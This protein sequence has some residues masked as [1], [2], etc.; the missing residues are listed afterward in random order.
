[1]DLAIEGRT[2]IVAGASRG[3]GLGIARELAR[4]G[5]RVA[6]VGRRHRRL[7]PEV[8]A[9]NAAGGV[10]IAIEADMTDESEVSRAV[11]ETR[12][13]F[14]NPDIA[15]SM[16]FYVTTR[17][18]QDVDRGFGGTTNEE[19]RKIMDDIVMNVVYLTR[20]V[21]PGMKDRRWGRLINIGTVAMK[22]PHR[23]DPIISSNIRVAAC[24]L[25]KTLA[26]E[27]GQYG[28]TA[29]VIAP[30]PVDTPYF[31]DYVATL[32]EAVNTKDKWRELVPMRRLGTEDDA[33]ALAAFLASEK[34]SW[35]TGQTIVLD[36]GY[37]RNLY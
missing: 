30:G 3:M 24:G 37:A 22:E 32:P 27:Y 19:F 5:V 9:I 35:I 28:I 36:G 25:M 8:E 21:L 2:A 11:A 15:V 31:G 12:A 13:V 14:G 26:N 7:D 33:G 29:N 16:G 34:A 4:E 10:A 6:M 20:E 17:H 1:V 18:D 23:E